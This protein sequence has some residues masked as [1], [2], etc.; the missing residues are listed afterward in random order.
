MSED[1][2]CPY[3]GNQM[4]PGSSLPIAHRL[5]GLCDCGRQLFWVEGESGVWA[6]NNGH[7]DEDRDAKELVVQGAADGRSRGREKVFRLFLLN[8]VTSEL[9]KALLPPPR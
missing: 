6:R 4:K 5:S 2:K 7:R 8:S 1:A 9:C 3:C